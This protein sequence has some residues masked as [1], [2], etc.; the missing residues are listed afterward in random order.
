MAGPWRY[1]SPYSATNQGRS[2]SMVVNRGS[3]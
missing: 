1:R 3:G 2:E